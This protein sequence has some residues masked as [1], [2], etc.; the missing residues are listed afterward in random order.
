[1]APPQPTPPL[2]PPAP[3]STP[4][5]GVLQCGAGEEIPQGV[6]NQFDGILD[7]AFSNQLFKR[8]EDFD[9]FRV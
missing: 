7:F 2:P 8:S 3:P 6:G 5:C 1:M 4:D 9:L